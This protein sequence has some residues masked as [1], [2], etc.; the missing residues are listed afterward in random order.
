M[1]IDGHVIDMSK[2]R[3][4]NRFTA[5][6]QVE[7]YWEGLRGADLV[8][9]RSQIDPRGIEDALNNAFIL[10]AIGG[11]NVRIRIAGTHLSDLL[12]ME[13]RGM[14]I[15]TFF[16]PASRDAFARSV[17]S[18]LESPAT[19]RLS[20]RGEKG[21]AQPAMAAQMLLL[22]LRSDLGDVTRILGC[23][24]TVGPLGQTPRRFELLGADKRKLEQAEDRPL[25]AP[26]VQFA[27]PELGFG[28]APASFQQAPSDAKPKRPSYLK[29]VK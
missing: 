5:C 11:G 20:L 9:N 3:G 23:L 8:P 16:S 26:T 10:E 6:N 25:P 18:V 24:E 21:W 22:P 12:G 14:P 4:Q 29:L 19:M 28:E 15:S 27:E 1:N 17:Q 13:V 7:A 2:K